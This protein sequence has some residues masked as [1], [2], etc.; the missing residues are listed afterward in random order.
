M[1]PAYNIFRDKY[2]AENE[3]MA[4]QWVGL[5]ESFPLGKNQSLTLL[6]V[7][8]CAYRQ[9]LSTTIQWEAPL[10]SRWNQL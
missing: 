7:L 9:V 10:S 1:C 6:I 4:N 2:K 5:V 3:G 8:C